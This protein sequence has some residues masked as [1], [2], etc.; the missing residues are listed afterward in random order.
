MQLKKTVYDELI[1]KVNAIKTTNTSNLDKKF[2]YDTIIG[3]IKKKILDHNDNKYINKLT[4]DNFDKLAAKANIAYFIKR[5][6]LM[7][8]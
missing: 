7:K 1:G 2:D 3:E 6:I 4:R 5:Q 8:N